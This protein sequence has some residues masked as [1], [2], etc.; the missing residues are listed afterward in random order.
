MLQR[1]R[2][3]LGFADDAGRGL[4]IRRRCRLGHGIVIRLLFALQ[5]RAGGGVDFVVVLIAACLELDLVDHDT[6]G[7]VH[8]D[9]QL[10]Q[11]RCGNARL[12]HGNILGLILADIR[13]GAGRSGALHPAGAGDIRPQQVQLVD[14]QGGQFLKGMEGLFGDDVPDQLGL[15]DGDAVFIRKLPQ[16]IILY[17]SLAQHCAGEGLRLQQ[18]ADLGGQALLQ[19]RAPGGILVVHADENGIGQLIEVSAFQHGADHCVHSYIHIAAGKIHVSH[20]DLAVLVQRINLQHPFLFV[21]AN[22]HAGVDIQ[23]DGGIHGV[24]DPI[25]VQAKAAAQNQAQARRKS[26]QP[27]GPG[28]V[29]LMIQCH[30]LHTAFLCSAIG[31]NSVQHVR[32]RMGIGLPDLFVELTLCHGCILLLQVLPQPLD[33]PVIF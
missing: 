19:G 13:L 2:F 20:D 16:V 23:G 22:L 5:H 25:A 4:G 24:I 9:L 12:A 31:K 11:S 32:G 8:L 3:G 28:F 30:L 14:G 17:N 15:A 18:L 10:R 27:K 7:G 29:L 1:C 26:G 21:H 33:G 6:V